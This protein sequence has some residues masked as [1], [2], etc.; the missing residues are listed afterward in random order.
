[1]KSNSTIVLAALAGALLAP[2]ASADVLVSNMGSSSTFTATSSTSNQTY[3][4]IYASQFVTGADASVVLSATARLRNASGFGLATYEAYIYTHDGVSP[5]SLVATFDTT[6]TIADGG[7]TVGVSFASTLG[8]A[9]DPNT[10]YWFGVY[11][12]TGRYTGWETVASDAETSTAGWTIDDDAASLYRYGTSGWEW[13]DYSGSYNGKVFKYSINGTTVPAPG[14][15]ALLGAS[16]IIAS[17]R[18]RA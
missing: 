17:R 3:N 13:E 14:T 18:R 8:I 4:P 1:M 16:G 6:P 10:T 12:T 5:G 2:A 7:G 9:L 15:L 11:N